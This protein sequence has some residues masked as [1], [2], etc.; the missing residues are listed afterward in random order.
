MNKEI[1][2]IAELDADV[3]DVIAAEYLYNKG[4]LKEVVCDPIP[5]TPLGKER[6]A[7]LEELGITVSNKMPPIAKYVF[8]GGALTE[9]SR[10]LINHK[11]ECLVMNGGFVGCN[12]MDKPLKKFKDK[13]VTR[14]FNFNCDINA[15][16]SVLKNK[17]IDKIILVGK[18]VCHNQKN[19]LKGIWQCEETLLKN[20]MQ[21]MK[22]D[23]M[24]C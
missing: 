6:K 12:I 21:K 11:I 1:I 14:T 13:L 16:D 20:I 4:V 3:D 2:Y 17:N 8:V 10:Y 23:N 24:I 22:K 7:Q 15:T 9:L 18:N 5:K 19:T